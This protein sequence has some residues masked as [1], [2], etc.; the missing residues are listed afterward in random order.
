VRF[1]V[2]EA[3]WSDWHPYLTTA[4]SLGRVGAQAWDYLVRI[5]SDDFTNFRPALA[6][7]WKNLD[8]LTW[9]FKLRQGV[10]FHEGQDFT[11]ADV[12]ASIEFCSGSVE[13]PGTKSV[14]APRWVPTT[15]EVADKYTVRLKTKTPFAPLL[16]MLTQ[17]P[18]LC[19][20]E[21]VAK[22]KARPNGTGPFR[23]VKDE[24]DIKTMEAFPGHW[25]T[26]L[27]KIKT[28]TNEYV[29]DAQT[30]L[31]ALLAGQCQIIDRVPAEHL[32]VIQA[33]ANLA[34]ITK[35]RIEN[36]NL[37][38]RQGIGE[39][40]NKPDLRR[41][42]AWSID[43]DAIATIVGG[44]NTASKSHIPNL[45]AYTVEQSPKYTSNP[46]K[47]KEYLKA[48]GFNS[49]ADVPEFEV[50]ASTGFLPRSKE[51]AEFIVASLQKNGF[52]V[53]LRLTD[54]AGLVDYLNSSPKNGY[55]FHL[56][57]GSNGDPHSALSTLYRPGGPYGFDDQKID[58]M[59]MKGAETVD[60]KERAKVYADLQAYL[61][62][63]V[64]HLPL[65]NT[66]VAMAHVKKL[67]GLIALATGAQFFDNVSLSA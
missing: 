66:D 34:L 30:R 13:V 11:G 54:V 45:A 35:P 63:R 5:E 20:A 37:W 28:L 38:M 61:W 22:L 43:R 62:E 46:D 65:Y 1:L 42:F 7:E 26:G 57:W 56:T 32:P 29:Q 55:M 50:C 41:A 2:T 16:A 24:K 59:I 53:K 47:V 64:V 18:M 51:V 31:N 52:K 39:P 10:K 15:V 67:S 25:R 12:K 14:W 40:W 8:P 33:N 58:D 36:A 44:A 49:A 27:P 3:F 19:A 60:T 6:T 21:D 48:A 4:G 9:E 17:A 23:L